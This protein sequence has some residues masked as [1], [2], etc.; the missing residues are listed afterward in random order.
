MLPAVDSFG[1]R[2]APIKGGRGVCP[3]CGGEMIAKCG[4]T[5]IH[6]WAH[7]K[8]KDCDTWRE[9]MSDWHLA[10][11]ECFPEECREVWV[12]PNREHRADVKGRGKILEVQRSSISPAE[13]QEREQFYGDMAWMLCGEDFEG[14]FT[15]RPYEDENRIRFR[16]KWKKMKRCWLAAEKDIYIHFRKGIARM[17]EVNG[18]GEGVL[19]FISVDEFRASFDDRFDPAPVQ[20]DGKKFVPLI[21]GFAEKCLECF[22]SIRDI[23]FTDSDYH[24]YKTLPELQYQREVCAY[25]LRFGDNK[26]MSDLLDLPLHGVES[27]WFHQNAGNLAN[28]TSLPSELFYRHR[29]VDDIQI[30]LASATR[31]WNCRRKALEGWKDF[32]SR[33]AKVEEVMS[34]SILSVAE[35]LHN[36][37]ISAKR[38]RMLCSYVKM[39]PIIVNKF[40]NFTPQLLAPEFEKYIFR[41]RRD[42][43]F[44]RASDSFSV[45]SEC[46]PSKEQVRELLALMPRGYMERIKKNVV[47]MESVATREDQRRAEEESERQA[48]DREA[49]EEALRE[50]LSWPIEKICGHLSEHFS[51]VSTESVS[52]A[53]HVATFPDSRWA[54]CVSEFELAVAKESLKKFNP[55]SIWKT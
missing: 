39:Q 51:G 19:E 48:R 11:Q 3:G 31:V 26:L 5:N 36:E 22:G 34:R 29:T 27:E 25:I 13:I 33:V 41:A 50:R 49:R 52:L 43:G 23:V 6:H 55:L 1:K 42:P 15:M 21:P 16:F 30:Y 32:E 53:H 7:R 10:W 54:N 20:R 28:V 9:D 35:E 38:K 2:I 44:P 12:G 47:Y 18:N 45:F 4:D 14:R 24:F 40:L 46:Q 37:L 8:D 17:L